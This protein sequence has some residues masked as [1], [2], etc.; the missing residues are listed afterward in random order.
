MHVISIDI[1]TYSVKFVESNIDKKKITH[2]GMREIVLSQYHDQYP[3]L[4][5]HD[6]QLKVTSKYLNEVEDEVKIIFQAPNTILTN[7]FLELPVKNKKKAELMIPFQLEE[8]IPYLINDIQR[9]HTVFSE[10]DGCHSLVSFAQNQEFADEFNGLAANGIIPTV[11]TSETSCIDNFFAHQSY[12]G[13]YMILDIGHTTTK[14]YIFLNNKLISSHISYIAGRNINESISTTY[15]I[16]EDEA[17]IYKHQNCFFLTEKQYESVDENQKIFAKLMNQTFTPLLHDIKR[18]ELGFRVKHGLKVSNIYLCGGTSNIKNINNYITQKSGIKTQLL[19]TFDAV[20]FRNVDTDA[21]FKG[22]FNLA[23]LMSHSYKK[24]NKVLNLLNGSYAQSSTDDV[25]LHS[26]SF[27][28]LRMAATMAILIVILLG[29]SFFLKADNNALSSRVDKVLK[30]SRLGITNRERRLA[31]RT[32]NKILTKLKRK[33]KNIIDEI[34]SIQ[35]A[36]SINSLAPLAKLSLAAQG[37]KA[38]LQLIN[39]TEDGFVEAVFASENKKVLENLQRILLNNSLPDIFIDLD[40]TK[41]ELK[42]EFR[43]K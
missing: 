41:K 8:N 39:V 21:K 16:E 26:I 9:A 19:D 4:S 36:I 17:I 7:R 22:R 28:S 25:P 15:K 3:D 34:S 11:L 10:G 1:G 42:V 38:W 29:E 24:G 40:M 27:I 12:A 30:N 33:H 31:K 13:A 37:S 2:F 20:N 43:N 18:W 14:G 32:P 6:L 5:T 35:A 23:N